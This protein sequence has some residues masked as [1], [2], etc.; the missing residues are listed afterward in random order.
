MVVCGS[1]N[2]LCFGIGF[3]GLPGI[4]S[5]LRRSGLVSGDALPFAAGMIRL[6]L[7]GFGEFGGVVGVSYLNASCLFNLAG[8]T[9]AV[10][11]SK[12]EN[13]LCMDGN[14]VLP[15]VADE[16]G[17]V[18][19][20]SDDNS[21]SFLKLASE[22]AVK[23]L[24]DPDV[25]SLGFLLVDFSLYGDCCTNSFSSSSVDISVSDAESVR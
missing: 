5:G 20:E 21:N 6:F 2:G 7:L 17:L 8:V 13:I 10:L 12:S 3:C 16:A 25:V 19:N 9:L 11:R 18:D 1:P 15:S 22:D 24:L 23:I 4:S 14:G